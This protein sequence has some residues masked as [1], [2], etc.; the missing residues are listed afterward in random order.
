[1][2]AVTCHMCA[3]HKH[4]SSQPSKELHSRLKLL[5][6]AANSG[7]ARVKQDVSKQH[8]LQ[9]LPPSWL[10]RPAQHA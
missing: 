8:T 10:P 9:S 2:R 4:C 3:K 6:R 5:Q 7:S 1:M